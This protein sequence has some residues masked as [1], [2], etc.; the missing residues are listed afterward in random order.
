MFLLENVAHLFCW[1]VGKTIFRF[2]LNFRVVGKENLKGLKGPLIVAFNHSSWLDPLLV[3]AVIPPTSKL[4]PV[5][6]A[7]WYKHYWK[8]LPFTFASGSFP[9]KKGQG[10]ENTLQKGLKTLRRGGVV[11]IAPEE[12]RRRFG[13]RRNPRRGVAFLAFKT[14]SPILPI[15]IKGCLGLNSFD[16]FLRKRKVELHIGEKISPPPHLSLQ[17]DSDLKS[18][19]HYVMERI[20]QL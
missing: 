8:F 2:F 11:G 6:F 19:A 18:F 7:T 20:Y 14:K 15:Y 13:R 12:R 4:V 17:E 3:N 10:L 5:R 1:V 9:V 16:L